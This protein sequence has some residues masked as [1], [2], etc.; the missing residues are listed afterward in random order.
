[1]GKTHEGLILVIISPEVAATHSL[2]MNKP[3]GCIYLRPFGAVSSTVR[4]DIFVDILLA[5]DIRGNF[6]SWRLKVL[7][8]DVG[9]KDGG[10]NFR[11][12]FEIGTKDLDIEKSVRCEIPNYSYMLLWCP[13]LQ[14]SC[15]AMECPQR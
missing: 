8:E 7:L 5:I 4:S 1:M 15:P 10:A 3:V 13:T 14:L 11:H 2:L 12:K 6:R 9:Q